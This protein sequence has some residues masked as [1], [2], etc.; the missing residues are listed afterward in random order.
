[1]TQ[2]QH[3]LPDDYLPL[4]DELN[5]IVRVSDTPLE[6]NLYYY[7]QEAN[8]SRTSVYDYFYNKRVNFAAACRAATRMLEIGMNA[9]HSALLALANGVEYHGVDICQHAYTRPAAEFLKRQFGD[10]FHFYAGNSLE[11]LPDMRT[12]YPWLTFD[13]L[14]IDGH[15]GVDFCRKD[16]DNAKALSLRGAWIMI[17][18]TDMPEIRAYVD[19]EFSARRIINETP[20]GWV[21]N[22]HHAIGRVA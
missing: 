22:K 2:P 7:H 14:H 17:D 8:P 20:E 11:V 10:R 12:Q 6:G 9:G 4:L 18:D 1:M 3:L 19:E 5:R 21:N 16:T 13:L 15:H